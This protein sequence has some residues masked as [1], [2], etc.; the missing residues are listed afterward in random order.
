ME[1]QT[2]FT[3]ESDKLIV[4]NAQIIFRNFSGNA[5]KFRQAG[6]RSFGLI[7]DNDLADRL[8]DEQWNIKFLKPRSEDEETT[9][10]TTIKIN[11]DHIR[12]PNIWLVTKYN[13]QLLDENTVGMLDSADIASI[14]L[15]VFPYHWE[16]N[17][18]TGVKG[19]VKSMYVNIIEDA[20]ADKYNNFE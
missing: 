3:L 11:Y 15:E 7:L 16:T 9:P 1:S 12:K 13:K 10:F 6:T 8:I 18:K 5:D 20:F 14:D 19:Y 4:E 2:V 17:G